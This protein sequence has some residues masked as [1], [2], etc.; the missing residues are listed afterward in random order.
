MLLIQVEIWLYPKEFMDTADPGYDYGVFSLDTNIGDSLGY[1]GWTTS[2]TAGQTVQVLGYPDD[3]PQFE[4]WLDGGQLESVGDLI[5]P[6][7][8]LM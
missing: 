8:F 5:V 2:A 4:L 6:R 3:K 1:F 7:T